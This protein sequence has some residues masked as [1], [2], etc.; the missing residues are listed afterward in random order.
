VGS[1]WEKFPNEVGRWC[2]PSKPCALTTHIPRACCWA[3]S[4]GSWL[5]SK[6]SVTFI[7]I[8]GQFGYFQMS[9]FQILFTFPQ[10]HRQQPSCF[11]SIINGTLTQNTWCVICHGCPLW[12][13]SCKWTPEGYQFTIPTLHA[14]NRYTIS[15]FLSVITCR[16]SCIY[17]VHIAVHVRLVWYASCKVHTILKFCIMHGTYNIKTWRYVLF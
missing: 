9:L 15:N 10:P 17:C 6:I 11:P 13:S 4:G 16:R 5:H 2:S 7:G 14:L 1:K 3:L 12:F 8:L